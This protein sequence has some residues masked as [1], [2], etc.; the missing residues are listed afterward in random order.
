MGFTSPVLHHVV[1]LAGYLEINWRS[2]TYYGICIWGRRRPR[3]PTAGCISTWRPGRTGGTWAGGTFAWKEKRSFFSPRFFSPSKRWNR[4]Y[5]IEILAAAAAAGDMGEFVG[6]RDQM[7]KS[8]QSLDRQIGLLHP[9]TALGGVC[10]AAPFKIEPMVIKIG[11]GEEGFQ[12]R[13]GEEGVLF[14]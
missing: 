1:C 9:K 6:R 13:R 3:C 5:I 2:L 10:T 7:C 8:E 14:R 11:W 4:D 12:T